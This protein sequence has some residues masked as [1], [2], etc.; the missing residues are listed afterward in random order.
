MNTSDFNDEKDVFGLVEIY[1]VSEVYE[2]LH[3][4][5][6]LLRRVSSI[7]VGIQVFE[8]ILEVLG[9]VICERCII[10]NLTIFFSRRSGAL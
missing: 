9:K 4:K 1:H 7:E 10:I 3:C 2:F 5:D 8:Q 6:V